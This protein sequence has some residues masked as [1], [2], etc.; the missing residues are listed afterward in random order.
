MTAAPL[1]L[2]DDVAVSQRVH[3]WYDPGSGCTLVVAPPWAEPGLWS[4]FVD[5]ADRSYRTHG[6]EC[7]LDVGALASGQDTA[8]FFAAVDDTGR[9]LGG[10]RAKGPYTSAR[11][12]HALVEWAG[13][14]GIDD[15]HTMITDRLPFGVAEMK[16][17]WVRRGHRP[18]PLPNHH[19]GPHRPTHHGVARRRVRHGHRRRARP[20]PMALLR[21]CR[22]GEHCSRA[23]P[24]P[25]IRH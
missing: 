9:M 10:L 20:G 18:Q 16:S 14:P 1:D 21:R 13:E 22:R 11:E 23:V 7:A 6:V 8:L 25:P 17:A 15:V 5:G 2:A 4:D 3:R 19:P 24:R 12:S